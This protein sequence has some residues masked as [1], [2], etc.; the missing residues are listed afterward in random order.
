MT[1]LLHPGTP[2]LAVGCL[3]AGPAAAARA[4]G[5][6]SHDHDQGPS[7]FPAEAAAALTAVENHARGGTTTSDDP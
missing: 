5:A 6:V 3:T 1:N 7:P 2:L 4:A